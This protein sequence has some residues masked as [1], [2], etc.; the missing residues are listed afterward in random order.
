MREEAEQERLKQIEEEEK[1]NR[2]RRSSSPAIRQTQIVLA[3]ERSAH[4]EPI[5][6]LKDFV[7]SPI[8]LA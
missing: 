8:Y 5:P 2:M 4:S 7:S 1:R 6:R 3:S